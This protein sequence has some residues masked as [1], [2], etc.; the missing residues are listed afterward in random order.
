MLKTV[1]YWP[2]TKYGVVLLLLDLGYGF[3]DLPYDKNIVTAAV[4]FSWPFFGFMFWLPEELL[5]AMNRG[6]TM[7]GNALVSTI[8][9]ILICVGIDALLRFIKIRRQSG[10]RV[11]RAAHYAT[12]THSAIGLSLVLPVEGVPSLNCPPTKVH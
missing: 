10:S 4:T 11:P 1:K 9:G 5:S 6:E 7:L 8:L 2:V 12:I 3:L